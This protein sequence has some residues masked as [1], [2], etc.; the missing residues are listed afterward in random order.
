MAKPTTPYASVS[1]NSTAFEPIVF[2][3]EQGTANAVTEWVNP[4]TAQNV[5]LA[6]A[7][8][9]WSN[10]N[11]VLSVNGSKATAI[12]PSSPSI[13]D[14]LVATGFDFNL[15]PTYGV[16]G[17]EA[18]VLVNTGQGD[19][20]DH[21]VKFYNSGVVGDNQATS[22]ATGGAEQYQAW[23]GSG[24]MWGTAYATV[25]D[26]GNDFG[27]AVS[28]EGPTVD[29]DVAVDVMQM[30]IYYT[31]TIEYDLQKPP[32]T[33]D[34]GSEY[35]ESDS[36]TLDSSVVT[37]DSLSVYLN[38]FTTATVGNQLNDKATTSFAEIAKPTTSF[39]ETTKPTTN[40]G[41]V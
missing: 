16:T 1:K 11:N 29:L 24:E 19:E 37:L 6:G 13:T 40:Y 41:E 25:A 15:D 20:F 2:S 28:F 14:Y 7:T 12:G 31:Y 3:T 10:A 35:S 34:T 9:Q 5:S 36:A 18:R 39:T 38:G 8:V 30:R 32:T 23:G 4:T 21:S 33:Y 27:F 22:T 26:L 17:I